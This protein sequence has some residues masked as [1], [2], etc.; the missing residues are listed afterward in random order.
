[1]NDRMPTIFLGG[2]FSAAMKTTARGVEFNDRLKFAIEEVLAC[3]SDLGCRV[4]SS[5]VIDQYGAEFDASTMVKRDNH[6]V[7]ECDLYV[8]LLPLDDAGLPYRTDG[9]FVELGLALAYQK[10]I[11]LAIEDVDHAAWSYY[12][13]N[14]DTASGCIHMV[15]WNRFMQSTRDILQTEI[16]NAQEER[17]LTHKRPT[18]EQTT[19][20]VRVLQSLAKQSTVEEVDFRGIRLKVLPGVFSPK[21]SHAPDYI[22]ENWR[23][24]WG[25]KVLDLGCGSGVLGLYALHSGAGKLVAIDN[26]PKACE[27][28]LLNAKDLGFENRTKVL[29]GNAYDPLSEADTFDVIILSPPYWNKPAHT[30]LEAACFDEDHKFLASSV[31]GAFKHLSAAGSV[32]LVFSDQ[33]E[34]ARLAQLIQKSGLYVSRFLVQRPTMPGGHIRFFYELTRP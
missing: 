4:F 16:N 20:A 21:V 33:G 19:D 17:A 10:K 1:M 3:I 13:R 7:K 23:I 11:V 9:T 2:P 34:I 22:I 27:N 5:H 28:T 14:L 8:A 32:F 15:E 29:E 24:P 25:C 31:L 12:V 26:N 18:R 6:W 30:P